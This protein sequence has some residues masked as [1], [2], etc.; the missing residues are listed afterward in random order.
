MENFQENLQENPQKNPQE[1]PQENPIIINT[2]EKVATKGLALIREI[3][4]LKS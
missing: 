2:Q 1:N 4:Q 3:V